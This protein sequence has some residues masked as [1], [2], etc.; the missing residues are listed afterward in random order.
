MSLTL[1]DRARLTGRPLSGEGGEMQSSRYLNSGLSWYGVG[2][3]QAAFYLGSHVKVVTHAPGEAYV[4]ELCIESKALTERWEANRNTAY[5]DVVR[6]RPL[7]CPSTLL[8]HELRHPQPLQRWVEEEGGGDGAAGDEP[9]AAESFTRLTIGDLN[10]AVFAALS[11]PGGVELLCRELAHVFHYYVHGEGGNREAGA[12]ALVPDTGPA[13]RGAGGRGSEGSS[14]SAAAPHVSVEEWWGGECRLR[15]P[16]SQV[17]DCQETLL[18]RAARAEFHFRV[19]VP[20]HALEAAGRSGAPPD[21][22]AVVFGTLAYYPRWTEHS[23]AAPAQQ[24][25]ERLPPMAAGRKRR[26]RLRAT[27]RR[28]RKRRAGCLR[29]SGRVAS[30][31][32]PAPPR[33]PS[34]LPPSHARAARQTRMRCRT[35][36]AAVCVGSCSSALH[37]SPRATSSLSPPTCPPRWRRR[38]RCRSARWSDASRSGCCAATPR[39][40]G[41]P[42]ACAALALLRPLADARDRFAKLAPSSM[43]VKA[44]LA[45]DNDH[46][47]VYET[48]TGVLRT[49]PAAKLSKGDLL[50]LRDRSL[51]AAKVVGF[52]APLAMDLKAAAAAGPYKCSGGEVL[53]VQQ[54]AAMHG[55][56]LRSLSLRRVEKRL[57]AAAA[58]AAEAEE[59]KKAPE[60]VV[61]TEPLA[62]A[63]GLEGMAAFA[64]GQASLPEMKVLVRSGGGKALKS[65][66]LRG[67]SRPVVVTQSLLYRG[68]KERPLEEV[69]SCTANSTPLAGACFIFRELSVL[70]SPSP[71]GQQQPAMARAGT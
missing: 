21:A 23:D 63:C 54:P 69:V 30:F 28:M 48:A 45:L 55:D 7:R 34:S 47:T 59:L 71:S 22:P 40:T 33:C 8:P 37:S 25:A 24:P 65:V 19:A 67:E 10:P 46:I 26:R 16:L 12:P 68:T 4:H 61:V 66:T 18:L 17:E 13:P 43:Q 9:E 20:P 1:A 60:E 41:A 38:N 27:A 39:W 70:P 2:S 49:D 44:R 36:V 50:Q 29:R 53:F 31:R 62:W 58:A 42:S 52:L 3:K 35:A 15:R 56:F 51:I 5:E 14:P 6:H 32:R 57:D 64:A 11:Y